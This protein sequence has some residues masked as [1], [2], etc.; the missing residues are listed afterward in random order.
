MD[1]QGTCTSGGIGAAHRQWRCTFTQRSGLS[2]RSI[3][4]EIEVKEKLDRNYLTN[5]EAGVWVRYVFKDET[6]PLFFRDSSFFYSNSQGG[7]FV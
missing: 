1:E 2:D 6:E 3:G 4:E 7:L 5:E